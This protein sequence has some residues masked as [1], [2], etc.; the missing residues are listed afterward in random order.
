MLQNNDL[1]LYLR[2]FP[3]YLKSGESAQFQ[4]HPKSVN[5]KTS[6]SGW[7]LRNFGAF[8][9]QICIRFLSVFNLRIRIRIPFECWS[10][11]V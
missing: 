5:K 9:L 7:E 11:L 4:F 1:G 10:T 8:K 2:R 3:V 6:C